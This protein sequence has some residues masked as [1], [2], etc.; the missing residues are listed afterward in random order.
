ML[1]LSCR[2]NIDQQSL[3]VPLSPRHPELGPTQAWSWCSARAQCSLTSIHWSVVTVVT[4]SRGQGGR[5]A[6]ARY[7]TSAAASINIS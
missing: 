7:N 2:V 1:L 5:G 3:F 4:I 6:A